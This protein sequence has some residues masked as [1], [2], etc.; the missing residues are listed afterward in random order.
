MAD[1]RRFLQMADPHPTSAFMCSAEV[2]EKASVQMQD[3]R[4]DAHCRDLARKLDAT[5]QL[6]L[7][8]PTWSA[9]LGQ[10]LANFGALP[11]HLDRFTLSEIPSLIHALSLLCL[12]PPEMSHSW[13]AELSEQITGVSR[14]QLEQS[15]DN[16]VADI[17]ERD[18]WATAC[19]LAEWLEKVVSD[20]RIATLKAHSHARFG[21]KS[22]MSSSSTSSPPPDDPLSKSILPLVD[23]KSRPA[24]RLLQVFYEEPGIR[25]CHATWAAMKVYPCLPKIYSTNFLKKYIDQYTDLPGINEGLAQGNCFFCS[26]LLIFWAN[27]AH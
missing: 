19:A 24:S 26:V 1:M 8:S 4:S 27:M 22:Q 23:E 6:V 20:D 18:R 7:E 17:A 12:Q 3:V 25:N 5:L 16:Q 2:E 14:S 21:A 10:P 9:D 15:L 11:Y 13:P